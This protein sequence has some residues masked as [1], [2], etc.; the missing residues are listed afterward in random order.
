MKVDFSATP[1]EGK[2]VFKELCRKMVIDYGI[3]IPKRDTNVGKLADI[4]I[5]IKNDNYACDDVFPTI[6]SIY[7]E[8]IDW[9]I[10]PGFIAMHFVLVKE[11]D[12]PNK[13]GIATLL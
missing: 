12:R 9:D 2:T 6:R 10:T 11:V 7:K 5:L 13:R 8:N 1:E 3:L 4:V